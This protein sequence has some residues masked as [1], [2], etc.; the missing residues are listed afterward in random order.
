MGHVR[1]P[2]AGATPPTCCAPTGLLATADRTLR[3]FESS[4]WMVKTFP[5]GVESWEQAL[6][7][8]MVRGRWRQ[9]EYVHAQPRSAR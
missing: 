5:P 8:D 1:G 4:E 7:N 2:R 9:R 3:E 6:W